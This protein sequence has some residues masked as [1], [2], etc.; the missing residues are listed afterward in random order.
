MIP[1]PLNLLVNYIHQDQQ[2]PLLELGSDLYHSLSRLVMVLNSIGKCCP[3]IMGENS[4]VN[5]VTT[6]PNSS[7]L[8]FH[9]QKRSLSYSTNPRSLSFRRKEAN[10]TFDPLSRKS[11]RKHSP[12]PLTISYWKCGPS[13]Q[14]TREI[15]KHENHGKK[16]CELQQ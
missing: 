15:L 7:S 4:S 11:S 6:G 1:Y 14:R 13:P 8:G 9:L 12:Y 16:K 3:L 10:I 2:S 5:G